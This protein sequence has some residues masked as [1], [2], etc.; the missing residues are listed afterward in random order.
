MVLECCFGFGL[1]F[2]FDVQ[3][4]SILVI[5]L[6]SHRFCVLCVGSTVAL[7]SVCIDTTCK[8]FCKSGKNGN[9]LYTEMGS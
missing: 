6:Y 9:I 5:F 8:I 2:T 7:A 1:F 4:M 3:Y